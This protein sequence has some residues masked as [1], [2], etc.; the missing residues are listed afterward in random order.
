MHVVM[1][2]D[3]TGSSGVWSFSLTLAAALFRIWRHKVTLVSIGQPPSPAQV[4][5][6]PTS[7][8]LIVT[9]YK[10][11]WQEGLNGDVALSSAF[12]ARLVDDMRPDIVHSNH[13]CYGSLATGVPKVVV[14]HS[15]LLS[16]LT[17][18]RY[19]GDISRLVVP[20]QLLDYRVFVEEGLASAQV[21]VC[22]SRFMA[23]ALAAHY[24][25]RPV[26][27]VIPNG[28]EVPVQPPPAR[29]PG[30]PLTAI[31]AGRLWDDAKN[32]DL[33]IDGVHLATAPTRLL[34]VGPT[35]SPDG[36][37]RPIARDAR[38]EPLGLLTPVGVHDAYQQ[39]DVYLAVSRY[40]PFG[41]GPV[42]AALAGCAVICNDLPSYREVWGDVAIYIRRNDAA[43]LA[44]QLDTLAADPDLL[45]EH[46]QRA[47]DR[48]QHFTAEAMAARYLEVYEHLIDRTPLHV[49]GV[50]DGSAGLSGSDRPLN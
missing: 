23:G 41:L 33:A 32:I 7:A 1:T 39:A 9:E 35:L 16:R 15:D 19:D 3:A 22:P 27:V 4:A 29:P 5:A 47:R 34:A 12:I 37:E 25:A 40:E 11:E 20:P 38:V 50:S 49:A 14:A 10:L 6:V 46:Q 43:D 28:V 48:A 18:C 31:I 44:R 17:W 13:Y 26:T 21:V 42:E 24:Q 36:L 30:R 8:R 45:R 2:T